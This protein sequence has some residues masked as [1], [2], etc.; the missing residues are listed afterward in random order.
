MKQPPIINN[1]HK[2]APSQGISG[3]PRTHLLSQIPGISLGLLRS[4]HQWLWV[5][6]LQTL[7]WAH[8][9][10]RLSHWRRCWRSRLLP[11][12][13]YHLASGHRA[14]CRVPGSRAPSRHCQSGHQPGRHGWRCTHAVGRKTGSVRMWR[15]GWDIQEWF[16]RKWLL[17]FK[18]NQ[19]LFG[20]HACPGTISQTTGQFRGKALENHRYVNELLDKA[21]DQTLALQPH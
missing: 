4:T 10:Q 12:S 21:R 9:C 11:Q 18:T 6:G 3:I 17:T 13:S 2:C 7:P 5:P 16:T 14:G 1:P 8:A 15:I 19:H 20:G